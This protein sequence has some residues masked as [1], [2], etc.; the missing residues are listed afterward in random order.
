MAHP[1]NRHGILSPRA[2]RV[3]GTVL[4]THIALGKIIEAEAVAPT[5]YDPV[6]LD[7]L[8]R[9]DLAEGNSLRASE[10]CQQLMLSPSHISRMLDRAEATQLVKRMPDPDDRRAARV[11]L[12]DK[13]RKVVEKFAPLLEGLIERVVFEALSKDEIEKLVDY[14]ERLEASARK[15]SGQQP[16]RARR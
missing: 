3:T 14:L 4:A 15:T 1:K 7:L 12:T 6:I 5:G 8:T 11:V 2:L 13:G 16:D 10:I 9:L